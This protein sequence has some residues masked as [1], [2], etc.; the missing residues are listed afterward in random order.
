MLGLAIILVMF[1]LMIS[2]IDNPYQPKRE[3]IDENINSN[4]WCS[5]KWGMK[6]CHF[7]NLFYCRKY[8]FI[9]IL[10]E[11]S[12][13]TGLHSYRDL[14]H[15]KL[16]PIDDHSIVNMRLTMV[17]NMEV[18][19][20]RMRLIR[21]N[22]FMIYRFKPDNIL[23]VIH[24]DLL[25]LYTT[26]KDICLGNV[27]ECS[28]KY[29]LLLSD[30]NEEGPY[31]HWYKA[32]SS[33]EPLQIKGLSD[34]FIFCFSSVTLGIANTSFFQYGFKKPQGPVKT[35]LVQNDIK[36]FRNYFLKYFDIKIPLARK[37]RAV[38]V[39]SR[40]I[41]RKIINEEYI[42]QTISLAMGECF[43]DGKLNLRRVDMTRN[44]TKE[45]LNAIV[46]SH[47]LVAV[48]GAETILSL[49]LLDQAIIIELFPFGIVREYVS[50]IYSLSSIAGIHFNYLSWT[51]LME[52]N[53]VAHPEYPS[54]FGGLGGLSEDLI[55]SIYSTKNVSAVECCN[56]PYYLFR[57][58]QDTLV[59]ESF[60][61]VASSAAYILKSANSKTEVTTEWFFPGPVHDL[62]CI[63]YPNLIF[64][65]WTVPYNLVNM[66]G[67]YNV[68]VLEGARYYNVLTSKTELYL[69]FDG[70]GIEKVEVWVSCNVNERASIDS[71]CHCDVYNL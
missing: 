66:S 31:I 11:N 26:F 41:N 53:S 29:H 33:K 13:I 18:S 30:P 46:S 22:Y 67:V 21:G 44:T 62:K 55:Q 43:K 2:L 3:I 47:I 57:M 16:S 59:D 23:H 56:N 40:I 71:Y 28:N 6:T 61:R 49:F 17:H 38:T 70:T 4:V 10:T 1:S 24:D 63:L 20:F 68:S 32:L 52:N 58:Y 65:T 64:V 8:G 7:H 60:Q 34:E 42:F 51:N 48:H 35:K 19:S 25:P 15:L 9:F 12:I 69:N 14:T 45:I 39:V 54:Q 27:T 5:P 37:I 50:P 36:E